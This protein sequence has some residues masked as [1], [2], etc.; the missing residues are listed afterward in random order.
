MQ[1]RYQSVS[2][3]PFLLFTVLSQFVTRYD[4][5]LKNNTVEGETDEDYLK[6]HIKVIQLIR[7]DLQRAIEYYD[8][9]FIK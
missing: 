8:K 2:T 9:I 3:F 5:I 7:A 1:V 6:Y 4:H